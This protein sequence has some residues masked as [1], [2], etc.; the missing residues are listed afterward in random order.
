[1]SRYYGFLEEWMAGEGRL[2]TDAG[3]KVS[4]NS[5]GRRDEVILFVSGLD[6][7]VLQAALPVRSEVEARRA[8]PFAVEDDIAVALE[9]VHIAVGGPGETLQT[10]RQMHV[11]ARDT[12]KG[13]CKWVEGVSALT[14]AKFVAE[15]SVLADGQVLVGDTR[16]LA[17]L[18]GK[19]F[20]AD[21]ALPDTLFAALFAGHDV[22]NAPEGDLLPLLAKAAEQNKTL[23]DLRQ[24][25]FRPRASFDASGLRPWR[26]VGLLA[27]TLALTWVGTSVIELRAL[28][29]Q[30]EA[31]KAATRQT[32]MSMFPDAPRNGD[33]VRAASSAVRDANGGSGLDFLQASAALYEALD[34]VPYA[35]LRSVRYD[36]VDGGLTARI[37][38]AGYGDD[39]ELKSV[40]L[41][42]GLTADLGDARLEDDSVVGDVRLGG[43]AR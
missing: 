32:Y 14:N 21:R 7:S 3:K 33:Y 37:A 2:I 39:A 9:D 23:V 18:G 36:Q 31:E 30:A 19:A 25:D 22:A 41:D 15:Q 8:A 29:S 11:I 42:A 6:V 35:E 43:A 40:L 34:A 12:L 5:A 26:T 17:K 13:W 20:A 1:M 27:A 4:P 16:V 38:Y 28:T 10:P 24:G